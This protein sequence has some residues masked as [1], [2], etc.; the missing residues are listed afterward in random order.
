M[1]LFALR[2]GGERRACIS[3]RVCQLFNRRAGNLGDETKRQN[4]QVKQGQSRTLGLGKSM[5]N[6]R[7][8]GKVVF[9]YFRVSM[10]TLKRRVKETV[11]VNSRQ[12]AISPLE[13]FRQDIV[14]RALGSC[15]GSRLNKTQ[16]IECL[17]V[18]VSGY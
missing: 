6:P 14:D 10:A 4:F 13:S 5:K 11:K 8:I 15:I 9:G 2:C 18:I 12:V 1:V 3:D 17:D 7:P 16:S